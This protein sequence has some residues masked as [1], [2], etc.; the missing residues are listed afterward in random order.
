MAYSLSEAA[1]ACGLNKTTV[2]RSIVAGR[3]TATKDGLGQW[4]I[5]PGELHRLYPPAAE[6][7]KASH[8]TS[9]HAVVLDVMEQQIAML[10][11]T[12]ADVKRD[13]DHWRDQ[14]MQALRAL[15]IAMPA[16]APETPASAQSSWWP[17]RRA[18]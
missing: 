4:R 10:K 17:F 16:P 3:L 11:E 12:I 14:A 15:P 1:T 5:E 2:L 6:K 8:T 7:Q 13:R 18:G 9:H